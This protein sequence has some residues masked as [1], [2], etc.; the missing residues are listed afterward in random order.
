MPK[1]KE[2]KADTNNIGKINLI[3]FIEKKISINQIFMIRL[4]MVKLKFHS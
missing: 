1:E 2:L 3:L 4:N